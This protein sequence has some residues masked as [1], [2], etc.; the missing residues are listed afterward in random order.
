M[1]SDDDDA[2]DEIAEL[3]V[4]DQCL[5]GSGHSGRM[6]RLDPEHGDAVVGARRVAT[7]VAEASIERDQ[8]PAGP[9]CGV[10][11]SCVGRPR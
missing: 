1:T 6:L 5:H 4:I 9:C 11:H 7:N 8:E 3:V 2:P 10:E